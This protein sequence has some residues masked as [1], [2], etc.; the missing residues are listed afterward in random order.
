VTRAFVAVR[1]PDAVLDA[2]ERVA[3]TIEVDG[4][5]RTA[6]AQWHIT[7]QFLGNRADVD[8]VAAALA[9]LSVPAGRVRLGGIGAFPTGRRARVV[10]L[11]L[12]EGSELFGAL[13]REVGTR[14]APLGYEPEERPYHAHLTLARCK[15]PADVREVLDA[16][17]AAVVG[18]AWLVDEVVVYES[19]LHRTGAEYVP[20]AAIPLGP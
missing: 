9:G 1:P 7:L 18:N 15:A 13:A 2:V 3:E 11:G 5:A 14:L 16:A 12:V 6:R 8:V 20:R 17:D 4:A 10:W 19:R